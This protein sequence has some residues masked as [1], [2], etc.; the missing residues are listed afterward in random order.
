[1]FNNGVILATASYDHTIKLWNQ[2]QEC[3]YS[4]QYSTKEPQKQD[5]IHKEG[6]LVN[7]IEISHDKQYLGAATSFLALIYDLGQAQF[8]KTPVFAYNGYK[9]SVTSIGFFKQD[10][11]WIY[12]SSED[13]SI[14]IHDLTMKSVSKKFSSQESVNQVVLH[15]NE[16][17]LISAHQDGNLKVWDLRREAQC[18]KQFNLAPNIGLRSVS[19]ALNGQFF[20][21][22][23]SSGT[24]FIQ[25]LGRS[26]EDSSLQKIENAHDDY[27]L[28]CQISPLVKNIVTCS[29]DKT[30]KIWSLN[31]QSKEFEHKNTLFGHQKWVWD[32]A[33]GCDGEFLFSCS[34]DNTAKLW[35]LDDQQNQVECFTFKGHKQ[36]VNCAAINDLA[37]N[38]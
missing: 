26:Y 1:M 4:Y 37:I 21:A 12:T 34:S 20:C 2:H 25:M 23:D 9:R 38:S 6:F 7:K 3:L 11:R 15:P 31:P 27:I 17:E 30:I 32:V 22:A 18:I 33:Y 16:V 29:A 13:G 8:P 5:E 19:I 24:L 35:K 14:Q 10:N 36:T 28:K